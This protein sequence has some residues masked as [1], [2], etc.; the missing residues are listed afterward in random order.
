MTAIAST[1][2]LVT[3]TYYVSQTVNGIESTRT[4]VP[5]TIIITTP[6]HMVAF[7]SFT[8]TATVT[9]LVVIGTYI[10]QVISGEEKFLTK[11]IK[12]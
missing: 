2:I 9:N 12:E 5:V 4:A 10:K 7:Q 6:F 1:Y 11:F 3:K 8:Y